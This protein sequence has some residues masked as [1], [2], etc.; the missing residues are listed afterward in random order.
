MVSIPSQER[1]GSW[2]RHGFILPAGGYLWLGRDVI[3]LNQNG[4]RIHTM[5]DVDD[6]SVAHIGWVGIIECYRGIDI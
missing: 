6:G 3:R 4:A 1:P 5:D 2:M